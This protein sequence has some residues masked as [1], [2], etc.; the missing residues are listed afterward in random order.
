MECAEFEP[1]LTARQIDTYTNDRA[2][3]QAKWQAAAVLQKM[4]LP[5]RRAH[6]RKISALPAAEHAMFMT[7]LTRL[8][9]AEN[10]YGRAPLR[11]G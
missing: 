4:R 7:L 5:A 2:C 11:Q 9:D 6:D 3:A 10:A 1:A 8:V